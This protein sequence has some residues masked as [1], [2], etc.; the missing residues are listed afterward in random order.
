AKT[1]RYVAQVDVR[2]TSSSS[3]TTSILRVFQGKTKAGRP[4]ILWPDQVL[5]QIS[6]AAATFCCA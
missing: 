4:D 2:K 3:R 1:L 6:N 5:I